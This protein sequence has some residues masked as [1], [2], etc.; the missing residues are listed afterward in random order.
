MSKIVVLF[1]MTQ[2]KLV[3]LQFSLPKVI[4]LNITQCGDYN[5]INPSSTHETQ[6]NEIL[7]SCIIYSCV[8][9]FKRM[10]NTLK[11]A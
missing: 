11:N 6:N 1:R 7:F 5:G 4:S 8:A 9:P 2:S 10:Y 3:S